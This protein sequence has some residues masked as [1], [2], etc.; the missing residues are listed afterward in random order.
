MTKIV[1]CIAPVN[2]AVIK[3]W[4][5]Q[6]EELIIPL[7]DSLSGT[8]STEF[9]CAKTTIMVS[10]LLTENKFWLNGKEQS[11]D[12]K[13]LNNCIQEVRRRANPEL[14]QLNWKISICSENNFP[15]AAGLASSAAGYACLVSAFAALY[16][17]KGDISSIARRGS[18]SA[19][20][21]IYGGWVRWCKG[22][23]NDGS[24]SI[25]K[26]IAAA[27]HWL[28]MRVLILVVNDTRKKYSSTDGM[29]RGV[30]TSELLKYRSQTIVP[31]RIEAMVKA[32]NEK[33]FHTFARLTMEDSNQ[34]HAICLDTYPPCVYMNDT[35]HGIAELVHL[36]NEYKAS[37]KVAYTFDA[38]PNACL[39]LLESEVEEFLAVINEAFPPR[40]NQVDYLR[41]IPV[42]NRCIPEKMRLSLNIKRHEEGML[43]YIIHT[44]IGDGPQLSH[45]PEDH[46]LDEAGL[47]KR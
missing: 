2:I 30:K 36:Y 35:S 5:K 41:G 25:A 1:T 6:D 45:R 13:R 46:L 44:K 10:P 11:F 37:N 31:R 40:E 21:S 38:G 33:D 23:K 28:E 47:P 4:G 22:V 20:R 24:D 39:Y 12:N 27:S 32:I 16:E 34:F 7:N 42:T 9:M 8:I 43:K 29:Q 19:C 3:Y 26:Q 18:G 17:I 15:T 14:P